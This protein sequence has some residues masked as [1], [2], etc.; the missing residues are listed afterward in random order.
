MGR[1]HIKSMILGVGIGIIFASIVSMIYLAG[2]QPNEKLSDDEIRSRAEALGMIEADDIFLDGT[3][4]ES[5]VESEKQG[6]KQ[7]IKKETKNENVVN[8][9]NNDIGNDNN[10]NNSNGI[11]SRSNNGGYESS[12]NNDGSVNSNDNNS[13]DG[14][15]NDSGKNNKNDNDINK[16]DNDGNDNSVSGTTVQQNRPEEKSDANKDV[17][18][19]EDGGQKTQSTETM[20][21]DEASD[22]VSKSG[23]EKK[24][25][26][27]SN[28]NE[29]EF[30]IARGDT[31]AE[32]AETL[33]SSGL[34]KNKKEFI[35]AITSRNL[36][37]K[38]KAGTYYIRMGTDLD[39]IIKI[40]TKT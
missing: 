27:K 24:T 33:M 37:R 11:D 21:A 12:I 39:T 22:T 3:E 32:V 40:I 20:G 13:N 2:T 9:S 14:S 7:D 23:S 28:G 6:I 29:I 18:E 38:I 35:T 10:N 1:I 36:S 4:N 30:L 31:T 16:N 15:K 5:S 34:I 8:D 17:P 26:W 19:S 25:K